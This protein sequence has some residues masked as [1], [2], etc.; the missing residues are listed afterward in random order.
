M[1]IDTCCVHRQASLICVNAGFGLH[2]KNDTLA[3]RY[4]DFFLDI[5][6]I[7]HYPFKATSL[8]LYSVVIKCH[9]ETLTARHLKRGLK[10]PVSV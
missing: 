5:S 6:Q 3:T 1:V 9:T 8:H 10:S 2:I 4:P 7:A